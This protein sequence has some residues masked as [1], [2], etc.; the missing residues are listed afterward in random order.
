MLDDAGLAERRERA[1]VAGHQFVL[2]FA[3]RLGLLAG[4]DQA[5]IERDLDPRAVGLYLDRAAH[6]A[7]GMTRP[8]R[9]GR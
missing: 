2:D 9:G 1:R 4:A 6:D 7:A 8:Q 3:H 5:L